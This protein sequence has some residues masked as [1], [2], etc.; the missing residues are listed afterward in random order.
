M[1][2]EILAW[3]AWIWRQ[4]VRRF[5]PVIPVLYPRHPRESGNPEGEER[6]CEMPVSAIRQPVWHDLT[7]INAFDKLVMLHMHDASIWRTAMLMTPFRNQVPDR[8]ELRV[9]TLMAIAQRTGGHESGASNEDIRDAV[10]SIMG[11][12]AHLA[13]YTNPS[14]RTPLLDSRLGNAR[15]LL[16]EEG[17]IQK[18]TRWDR[19]N[20]RGHWALTPQ[21]LRMIERDGGSG[22]GRS[23]R[24]VAPPNSGSQSL[25]STAEWNSMA[26]AIKSVLNDPRRKVT[27]ERETRPD[28]TVIE[29]IKVE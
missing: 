3:T 10:V 14:G 4:A 23:V 15:T 1:S 5:S 12:P 16:R 2:K 6:R 29:R 8:Y 22:T 20:I 24:R 17:L 26:G 28:G 7:R 27:I 11:I 21:A 25:V 13:N 19:S 18:G 9:P